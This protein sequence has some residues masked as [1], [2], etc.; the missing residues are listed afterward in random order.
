M[1][2][3]G[4]QAVDSGRNSITFNESDEPKRGGESKSEEEDSEEEESNSPSEDSELS[5]HARFNKAKEEGVAS[6]I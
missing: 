6:R 5:E 3:T 1:Q 2:M 4:P